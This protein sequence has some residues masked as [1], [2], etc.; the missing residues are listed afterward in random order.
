MDET[1]LDVQ[2]LSL[3]TPPLHLGQESVELARRANDAVPKPSLDGPTASRC[4][5]RCR[6]RCRM[7]RRWRTLGFKGT[8][9]CGRVNDRN[10]DHS[11]FFPTFKSAEAL[12]VR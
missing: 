9:L 11:D 1:G 6:Y 5:P 4:W 12:K 8:M 3:T 10:L 7:R 2:V